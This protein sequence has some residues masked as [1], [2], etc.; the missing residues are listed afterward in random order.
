M[1]MI[2]LFPCQSQ[3]ASVYDKSINSL[4]FWTYLLFVTFINWLQSYLLKQ[5][6]QDKA[7]YKPVFPRLNMNI[8][9]FEYLFV[10]FCTLLTVKWRIDQKFSG[11]IQ[12][13]F[14]AYKPVWAP[15]LNMS[16]ICF[17]FLWTA[18]RRIENLC[19]RGKF[20]GMDLNLNFV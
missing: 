6:E 8:E 13:I 18:W 15:R 9:H 4:L 11:S 19:G 10:C 16:E 7:Q 12:I 14:A 2:F 17:F 3:N 5:M 20:N 1:R